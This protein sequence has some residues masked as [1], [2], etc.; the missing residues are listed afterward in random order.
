[1]RRKLN[2]LPELGELR[3]LPNLILENMEDPLEELLV[4]DR[5]GLLLVLDGRPNFVDGATLF[6][7]R[8]CLFAFG[9]GALFGVG[10]LFAFDTGALF[11]AGVLFFAVGAGL[12]A[13]IDGTFG[14]LAA[15][16]AALFFAFGDAFNSFLATF[17]DVSF[18]V[19]FFALFLVVADDALFFVADD[20]ALIAGALGAFTFAAGA[21]VFFD[22]GCPT[23]AFNVCASF[24]FLF[25]GLIRLAARPTN[26][27]KPLTAAKGKLDNVGKLLSN[28]FLAASATA[29]SFSSWDLLCSSSSS[30][31]G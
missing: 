29:T 26:F 10:D 8:I 15:R 20:D 3:A 12:L 5:D 17:F 28:Q 22:C 6:A 14:A 24:L 7:A 31:L 30:G 11:G 1:M 19:A 13:L 4:N 21:A 23:C 2:P 18:F 25:G 9:A 16:T 27:P